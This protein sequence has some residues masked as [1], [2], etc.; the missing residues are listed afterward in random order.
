MFIEDPE[1]FLTA[2][3]SE[4]SSCP[5][6]TRKQAACVG[7]YLFDLLHLEDL[8]CSPMHIEDLEEFL[9]ACQSE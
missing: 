1:E 9:T 5:G 7:L 8:R 3:Q 6:A 4:W 2:C